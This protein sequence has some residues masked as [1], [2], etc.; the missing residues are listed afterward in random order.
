M[1]KSMTEIFSA[2]TEAMAWHIEAGLM[3][4][5]SRNSNEMP[6]WF[7]YRKPQILRKVECRHWL[8]DR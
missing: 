4:C 3:T 7:Y 5:R 6:V 8:D 2:T 1:T